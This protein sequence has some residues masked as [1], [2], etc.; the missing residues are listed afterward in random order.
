MEK[1]IEDLKPGIS[2]YNSDDD[3]EE[4]TKEQESSQEN[5]KKSN[6]FCNII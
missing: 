2:E 1:E 4:K 3:K 6:Y 5:P